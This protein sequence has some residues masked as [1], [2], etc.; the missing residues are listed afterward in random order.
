MLPQ[1][2]RYTASGQLAKGASTVYLYS[3]KAGS[4]ITLAAVPGSKSKTIDL[5]LQLMTLKDVKNVLVEG[6]KGKVGESEALSFTLP[7][8]TVYIIRVST[9]RGNPGSYALAMRVK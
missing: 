1:V 6:N 8:S 3:G 5:K 4:R 7:E 2:A 9:A